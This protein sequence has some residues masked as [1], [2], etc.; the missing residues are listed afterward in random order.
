MIERVG[1]DYTKID[2][3]L[4]F[5]KVVYSISSITSV[6]LHCMSLLRWFIDWTT[7]PNEKLSWQ[8]NY[9][10]DWPRKGGL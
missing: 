3:C 4:Y 2:W 1:D 7:E 10:Y 6:R 5:M 8:Y 9:S